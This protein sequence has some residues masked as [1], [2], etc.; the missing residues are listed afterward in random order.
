M[1][2]QLG[3]NPKSKGKGKEIKGKGKGKG[4]DIKGKVKAND[5]KNE[6]SKKVKSDDRRKCF[7]CNK[8]CH[9][10]AECRQRLKDLPEAEGKPVAASPHPHD[11]TAI[12][13]LQ[14]LLPGERHSS[15][16][17]IGMSCVKVCRK[18]YR[19]ILD[20]EPGQ[21]GMLHK[22]TNEWIGLLEEKG[23]YVFDGWVSPAMTAGRK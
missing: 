16:F 23:V 11:A 5:V 7:C 20:S 2:M 4:K 22:H 17:V 19:I 18:G 12:V 10:R 1:P 6:S 21:S 3:A 8:T 9:V 14:C 15:T 13:P